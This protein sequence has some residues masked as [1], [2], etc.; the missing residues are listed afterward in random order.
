M[1]RDPRLLGG[2][3]GQQ[4]EQMG[5]IGHSAAAAADRLRGL[6]VEFEPDGAGALQQGLDLVVSHTRQVQAEQVALD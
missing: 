1:R 4:A 3:P 6:G 5:I 2:A